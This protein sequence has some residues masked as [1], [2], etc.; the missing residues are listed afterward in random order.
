MDA[1]SGGIVGIQPIASKYE[2]QSDINLCVQERPLEISKMPD[3]RR[4]YTLSIARLVLPACQ[5]SLG[6]AQRFRAAQGEQS[7]SRTSLFLTKPVMR[8]SSTIVGVTMGERLEH[9]PR[10]GIRRSIEKS[11]RI[12]C[13]KVT[14]QGVCG[15]QMPCRPVSESFWASRR[16]CYRLT[17]QLGTFCMEVQRPPTTKGLPRH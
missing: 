1:V 7:G 16:R 14:S 8:G 12:H 6:A 4:A 13:D 10:G 3:K 17:D 5:S 15:C 2:E 11:D 9:P